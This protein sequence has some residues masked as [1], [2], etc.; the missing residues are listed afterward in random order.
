MIRANCDDS[1]APYFA[2]AV[3]VVKSGRSLSVIG[4]IVQRVHLVTGQ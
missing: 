2:V 3:G 1:V 4:L